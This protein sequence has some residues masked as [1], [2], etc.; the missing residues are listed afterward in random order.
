MQV[1]QNM[2]TVILCGGKGTRMKEETEFKPKPMVEIGGMPMLWHIMK[3]YMHYG[4]KDFIIALGYKGSMIKEL[5]L[6][7]RTSMNDIKIDMSTGD[8]HFFSKN[9]SDF[10]VTL[11]D[12]G[13]ETLTGERVLRCEPYISSDKFMV[14]YGDGLS[15][16]N[17]KDIVEFHKKSGVLA[18][19]S[20]VHNDSRFG[21][22]EHSEDSGLITSFKE[23]PIM[24]DYINGGFMV[25]DKDS[26]KYF[27][28]GERL[29]DSLALLTN[30]KQLSMYK[31]EGFWKAAD[32]YNEV[33]Q[34]NKLWNSGDRPWAVWEKKE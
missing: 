4:Y 3:I 19:I 20:G 25:F 33:E 27:K 34:L 10:K 26:L 1:A 30:N 22:I 29:E 5:F 15:D 31:H 2:Q 13:S 12:T 23:K 9:D 21:M 11:V 17:V 32:T 28:K 6:G 16:I 7:W 18:T 8:I 24:H 14:T